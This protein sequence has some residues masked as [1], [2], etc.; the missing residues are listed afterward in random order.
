MQCELFKHL[1]IKRLREEAKSA[2]KQ[3]AKLQEA[4]EAR[5]AAN[6]RLLT[7]IAATIGQALEA[8]LKRGM[9]FAVCGRGDEPK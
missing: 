5:E 9:T 2:A 4:I 7:D 3:D 1:K 8:C 6:R